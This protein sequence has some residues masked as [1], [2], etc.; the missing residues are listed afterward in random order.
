MLCCIFAFSACSGGETETS[1]SSDESTVE[2]DE[3]G[4]EIVP[5]PPTKVGFVYNGLIENGGTITLFEAARSQIEKALGLE[6]CYIEG[7][8]VND[9]VEAVDLLVADGCNVIVSGS[10][11]FANITTKSAQSHSKVKY[12]SFGGTGTAANVAVFQGELYQTAN[13]CG[14]VAAYNSKSNILG[15][16]CD[17]NAYAPYTVIEAY[18]LGA[19]EITGAL[20]NVKLN[21]AFSDQREYVEKA[22]DDLAEQGCDVIMCYTESVYAVEYCEKKGIKVIGNLSNIPEI[23]P[24]MYLTGFF[25]NLNTYIID[26]VRSVNSDTFSPTTHVGGIAEGTARLVE[27]NSKLCF[28]GTEDISQTL[29]DFVKTGQSVIFMGE[30]KDNAGRVRIEKGYALT[31]TQSMSIDWVDQTVSVILD[32]T[33][34]VSEPTSSDFE[35]KGKNPELAAATV[36]ATEEAPIDAESTAS[37]EA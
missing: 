18:V 28:S 6:T 20:T 34:P 23:A 10:C 22:I 19:K 32:F 24:E 35:I 11:K 12:I 29:Y 25:Y 3:N 4:N 27:L 26:M 37:T 31:H 36:A 16:L 30:V 21:W 5:E 1:V 7:V 17:P 9:Y 13:I 8:L 33:Q 2:T 15:I 14:L